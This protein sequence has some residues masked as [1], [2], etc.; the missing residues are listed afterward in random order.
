MNENCQE[1]ER[2]TIMN[3]NCQQAEW[4]TIM[5]ENSQQAERQTMMNETDYLSCL[6][7]GAS[8]SRNVEEC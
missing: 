3:G 7:V 4:Q 6:V 1:A 8:V 5:N 2:Q